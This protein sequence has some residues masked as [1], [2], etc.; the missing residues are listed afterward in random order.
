MTEA[1]VEP[2]QSNQM[3]ADASPATVEALFEG[4]TTSDFEAAM[5]VASVI[6][7]DKK[8]IENYDKYVI[9]F[10]NFYGTDDYDP[11]DK[12]NRSNQQMGSDAWGKKASVI[13]EKIDKRDEEVVQEK[14][15]QKEEPAKTNRSKK[16]K[17]VE[18]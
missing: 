2:F 13:Q 8:I 10:K 7:K 12:L 18:I 14:L 9:A 1:V 17:K 4:S 3:V 16:S 6:K 11:I 15:K 5:K